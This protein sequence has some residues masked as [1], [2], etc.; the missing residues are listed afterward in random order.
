MRNISQIK[1]KIKYAETINNNNVLKDTMVLLIKSIWIC[2][3]YFLKYGGDS[4]TYKKDLITYM[5]NIFNHF[6]TRVKPVFV[7]PEIRQLLLQSYLFFELNQ[8]TYNLQANLNLDKTYRDKY[9][10]KNKEFEEFKILCKSIILKKYGTYIID[11]SQ[12]QKTFLQPSYILKIDNK[13]YLIFINKQYDTFEVSM[14]QTGIIRARQNLCKLLKV[15]CVE[16]DYTEMKAVNNNENF[17]KF[18]SDFLEL[19]ILV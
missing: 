1:D 4:L 10:K 6:A 8:E 5:I 16:L 3:Y 12:T 15:S 18:I 19:K 17:E 9:I 14:T 2:N 11:E 7:H 13:E